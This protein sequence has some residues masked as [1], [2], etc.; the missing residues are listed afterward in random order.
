MVRTPAL[1]DRPLNQARAELL[2]AVSPLAG[3]DTCPLM[4]SHGRVLAAPLL[5][6][7]DVPGFAA[8]VM[9]GYALPASSCRPGVPLPIVGA[10]AAGS[11]H[12]C[13]VPAGQVVRIATG[14]MLPEGTDAVVPQEQVQEAATTVQLFRAS[15]AG[16]WVRSASAEAARGDLLLPAGHRLRRSD[17]ARAMGC[18]LVTAQLCRQ[19]RVAL[20]IT[21]AELRDAHEPL[22]PGLI[23]DS[24]GPLLRLLLEG[25]GC[26]LVARQRVHDDP[27]Q[28]EQV[29][30]DLA[31]QADVL[32]STG[33]VSVGAVDHVRPLLQQ[34]GHL[35]FWRIALKPGRPFATGTLAGCRF[36]GLP[37]NP[38]S[39]AVTFLQLVWPALQKLEGGTPELWP[40]LRVTLAEPLL[41][42]AGRPEL[43]R[44][45]LET[46]E[47][48]VPW[49]RIC[50]DQSSSR[51][52]SLHGADLLLEIDAETTELPAG[53]G[54]MAQLL[55][56]PVL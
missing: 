52:G 36:F 22:T 30:L 47:A 42:R 39:A 55:R 33:G 6:P 3:A 12:G 56:R 53:H 8:A 40:R 5:A 38:V 24:N 10:A 25:L 14:A 29:L 20:L 11:P 23:H 43:V 46:D 34:L 13:P 48:G 51:L 19:P 54:V 1:K 26:R 37:G 9:D 44:A 21:G 49:A 27:A 16:Q 50:G 31:S 41:R 28:L 4:A 45:R 7:G 15:T 2:A 35:E 17:V 18:G 32:I